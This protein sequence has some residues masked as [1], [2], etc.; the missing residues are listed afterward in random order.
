M[1]LSFS[2]LDTD[3]TFDGEVPV[4]FERFG[5]V[6]TTSVPLGDRSTL[7]LAAGGVFGGELTAPDGAYRLGPG[8][9]AGASYTYRVLDAAWPRPFVLLSG[10]LAASAARTSRADG[11]AA[12]TLSAFDLRVG[13]TAG[14]TFADVLSP[15]VALRAFGGPVSW[16]YAGEAVTGT[17]DY[18]YQPALG[19]VLSYAPIDLTAEWAFVGERAVSVGLGVAF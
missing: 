17:D 3:L 5:A 4:A 1:G 13:A 18:H 6:V 8:W 9:V 19:A 7:D 14:Y 10:T 11:S 16:R 12:G 15:Y 2:V